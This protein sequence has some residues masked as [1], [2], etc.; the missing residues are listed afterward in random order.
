MSKTIG[1]ND[2]FTFASHPNHAMNLFV[3]GRSS[4]YCV[5]K[6]IGPTRYPFGRQVGT[7]DDVA[8][9]ASPESTYFT[10]D[11]TPDN[12]CY[13]RVTSRRCYPFSGDGFVSRLGGRCKF[14]F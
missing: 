7:A 13:F 5:E 6:G 14:K 8:I 10:N 3:V 12:I 9:G 1:V 11:D 2:R 4:V